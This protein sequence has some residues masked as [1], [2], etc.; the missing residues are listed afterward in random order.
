VRPSQNVI[1]QTW[2]AYAFDEPRTDEEVADRVG[3]VGR[4]YG[5][6]I[7]DALD[8]DRAGDGTTGLALWRRHDDRLRWPLWVEA[9]N[10]AAAMTAVPTGWRRV[11]D[12]RE[13]GSAAPALARALADEPRR[14]AELNPPFVIG[15]RDGAGSLVIV[16]DFLGAGR[17]YELRFDRG[18]AWSNRLGALPV[19]AGIRP[20]PDH[21]A[22]AVFA[23]A[24]WF[25]GE[26]TPIRGARKVP[27][28]TVISVDRRGTHPAG[29]SV[30]HQAT[31]APRRAVSPRRRRLS[32][33]ATA[34]A[35]HVIGLA[36]DLATAWDASLAISLTGGRDSRVSAAAAV[37]AGLEAT[38]NTGDQVP[39]E[40]DVVRELVARAPRAL[41]HMVYA[42]EPEDEGD[43]DLWQR[44]R[45]IHLVHDGVRNPQ[46]VRRP[47]EVPQRHSPRPTLS[48]H[49]GELG[50]GFY[51]PRKD[52]LRRLRRGRDR[53]LIEQL[54]RN[55]RRRHSAAVEE[56]YARYLEECERTLAAGRAHGLRGPVLLDWFYM[57]QRLPY[58]SGL[59]ARS[60][61]S[62]ACTVPA[63]VRGAFDLRPRDR[64][65][66][67]LH[68]AVVADL[69]PEWAEVPF[70]RSEGDEEMPELHRRR[71]W[72]RPGDAATVEE[73]IAAKSGWPEILDPA[74]IEAMWAEVRS[75]SGSADYEHV[76][77][78]VVWRAGYEEHLRTLGEAATAPG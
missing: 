68:R 4:H 76:F 15:V 49:G 36:E 50:H 53:A 75:G 29:I 46:E 67:R 40:V 47:S 3:R 57:A 27:P 37:A 59:G 6:L 31:D 12:A 39:G 71:I 7:A 56:G 20:E 5:G 69:V 38:F 14:A 55:A 54:E 28:A 30:E 58:R 1:E 41:E 22:W 18:W 25:L 45:E 2:L 61:R 9:G 60:G 11:V 35:E 16:N 10:V 48:G 42:P 70:F 72:E 62:S 77:Y 21:Q 8:R 26:G 17:L 23:A 78:R 52:K 19:F 66:A 74:R 24:G 63:F 43:A 34:A 32:R 64:L 73:M 65:K 13:P 51:Y 44:I 33:S